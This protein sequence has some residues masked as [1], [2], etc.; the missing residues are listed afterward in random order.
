VAGGGPK[1]LPY[2]AQLGYRRLAADD[3]V[4]LYGDRVGERVPE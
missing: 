4:L 1:R 2:L 3:G